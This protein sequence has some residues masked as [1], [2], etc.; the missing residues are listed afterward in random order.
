M[1]GARGVPRI[2]KGQMD[3]ARLTC[4]PVGRG[5][6]SVFPAGIVNGETNTSLAPLCSCCL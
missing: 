1:A 2:A 3:R 4:G 5:E 6:P